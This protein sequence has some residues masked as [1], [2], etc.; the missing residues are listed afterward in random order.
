MEIGSV[1]ASG[2]AYGMYS[3]Y[4]S[5]P[6]RTQAGRE[7]QPAEAAQSGR[8]RLGSEKEGASAQGAAADSGSNVKDSAQQAQIRKLEETD[9]KVRAHEQAHLAAASGLAVSGANFQ[10]TQGPDGK[11]YAVAGEVRIDTSEGRTPQETQDKAARIRAA[12]LAPADPSAQD[13]SVAAAAAQMQ[14]RAQAEAASQRIQDAQ[15]EASDAPSPSGQSY[16]AQSAIAAYGR[17]DTQGAS[18]FSAYA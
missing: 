18:G 8:T 7:T 10:F 11:Q 5:A 1:G 13:Q 17:G 2:A 16:A 4:A 6:V 14:L 9:R 15:G 12:A 3:A